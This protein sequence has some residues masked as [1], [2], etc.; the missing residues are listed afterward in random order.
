MVVDGQTYQNKPEG[1]K[2]TFTVPVS[3]DN[4]IAVKATT[5]AMFTPHDV[6]YTVTLNSGSLPSSAMK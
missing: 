5:E 3:L 1:G 4:G 2:S 6:D